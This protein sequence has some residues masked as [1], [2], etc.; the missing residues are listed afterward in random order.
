MGVVEGR[1]EYCRERRAHPCLEVGVY[2]RAMGA[3]E[4]FKQINDQVYIL[5]KSL[6]IWNSFLINT[7]YLTFCK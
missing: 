6:F 5:E 2:P 3:I 1:E 4:R 7:L